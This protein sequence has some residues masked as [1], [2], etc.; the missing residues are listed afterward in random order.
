[1]K[2]CGGWVAGILLSIAGISLVSAAALLPDQWPSWSTWL[3]GLRGPASFLPLMTRGQRLWPLKE[4]GESSNMTLGILLTLLSQ[5]ALA[6]R[7]VLEESA[8][9]FTRLDP[10]QVRPSL[11]TPPPPGG[12]G[13]K[14]RFS[15]DI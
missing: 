6:L 10:L 2:G 12:L 3:G 8:L 5:F 9:G 15:R 14:G 1:M 13:Q 7:L 11:Y 4:E